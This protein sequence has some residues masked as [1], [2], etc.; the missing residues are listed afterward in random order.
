MPRGERDP[1]RL[2][3]PRPLPL[4]PSPPFLACSRPRRRTCTA[5][6]TFS[7]CTSLRRCAPPVQPPERRLRLMGGSARAMRSGGSSAPQSA[8]KSRRAPPWTGAQQ[9]TRT[10][11]QQVCQRRPTRPARGLWR[12]SL[13][14]GRPRMP[15]GR[16][17]PCRRRLEVHAARGTAPAGCGPVRLEGSPSS[18]PQPPAGALHAAGV[19]RRPAGPLFYRVVNTH[20]IET[21]KGPQK[22]KARGSPIVSLTRLT[23]GPVS[24]VLRSQSTV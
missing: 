19:S 14:R 15:L 3:P 11:R 9:A 2:S 13:R 16:L 7:G 17:L 1:G 4:P 21:Q 6:Q 8:R 18:D 23:G 20:R 12:P 24:L 5:G 22:G 10:S